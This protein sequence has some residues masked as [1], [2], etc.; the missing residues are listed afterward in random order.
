MADRASE[1]AA[2]LKTLAHPIRLMLACSLAEGEYSVGQLEE[3]LN[4]HQPMLSQQLTVLRETGVVETRRV[5]KQIFYRL[6]KKQAA[7]LIEALYRIFCQTEH[8]R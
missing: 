1:V 8:S 5:G 3:R 6:T 7:Q 2:L 4:V